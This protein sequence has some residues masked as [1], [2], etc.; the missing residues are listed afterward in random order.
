MA[1]SKHSREG[2]RM[3]SFTLH[4]EEDADLVTF[5]ED[6][7][8]TRSVK[9]ALREYIKK[10]QADSK[11]SL[12]LSNDQLQQLAQ[13]LNNQTPVQEDETIHAKY[14]DILKSKATVDGRVGRLKF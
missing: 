4:E 9:L 7:K 12:N 2:R 1:G 11:P 10:K 6:N 13:L 3:Y 5:L 8:I 14:E